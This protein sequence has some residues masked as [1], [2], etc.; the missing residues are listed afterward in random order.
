M[1]GLILPLLRF[2]WHCKKGA[3]KRGDDFV[4]VDRSKGGKSFHFQKES[5]REGKI[6]NKQTSLKAKGLWFFTLFSS[7]SPQSIMEWIGRIY[8]CTNFCRG[9]DL[10]YCMAHPS[11]YFN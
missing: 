5:Y 4:V 8:T 7:T 10:K 3:E 2:C 11:F 1:I 6:T 9:T